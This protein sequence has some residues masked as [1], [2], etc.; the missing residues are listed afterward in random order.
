MPAAIVLWLLSQWRVR[1]AVSFVTAALAVFAIGAG[2]TLALSSGQAFGHTVVA[3]MNPL[4]G[5]GHA[6]EVFLELPRSTWLPFSAAA[7]GLAAQA[8]DRRLALSGWYWL[9][10]LGV[11]LYSLQGRGGDVN[12]LLESA[13]ATCWLAAHGLAAIWNGTRAANWRMLALAG[14]TA[15]ASLVWGFQTFGV[16]RKDGGVDLDRQQPIAEIAAAGAVLTEEPTMVLLAGK[17][18][19]ASDVFHLSMLQTAGRYDPT[20]LI[21]RIRQREFGLVVLRGDV[22]QTRYINGQPKWPESVRRAVAEYYRLSKRVDL[23]W[24]YVPDRPGQ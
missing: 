24:L 6:V 15:A 12:Y 2:A 19:I 4:L 7:L 11:G 14:L 18:L 20:D 23:Y 13:A 21:Q 10:A 17:P 5:V 16:W 9:I 22:R 3:H 1:D 8:R